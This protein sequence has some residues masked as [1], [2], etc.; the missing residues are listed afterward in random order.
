MWHLNIFHLASAH[1]WQI[2]N[3]Y[4]DFFPGEDTRLHL[5]NLIGQK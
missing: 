1:L 2:D 5:Q 4:V 3:N